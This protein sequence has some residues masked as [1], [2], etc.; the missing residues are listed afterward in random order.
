MTG[1]RDKTVAIIMDRDQ[2]R[3]AWCGDPIQGERGMDWSV[4]HR[5]PR[6]MGGTRRSWV[7]QAANGLIVHG[8]GTTGCHG[9]I[10]R[11]R[12]MAR[13]MGF[14]V[15]SNGVTPAEHIKIEHA[16]HGLAILL[17]EAPWIVTGAAVI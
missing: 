12:D 9:V 13:N 4:H 15:S 10:E 17:N 11:E 2:G 5:A 3:C 16:V 1:F 14:L 6:S 7:N 8:H